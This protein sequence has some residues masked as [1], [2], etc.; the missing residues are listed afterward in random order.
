MIVFVPAE[1]EGRAH[2]ASP[3][4]SS[5]AGQLCPS[6]SLIVTVPVGTP[7]AGG[8][9]ATWT[10]TVWSSPVTDGSGLSEPTVVAEVAAFDV[11]YRVERGG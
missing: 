1:L 11:L 6:E 7:N 8:T 5:V 2:E 4:A 10:E 3:E 9:A